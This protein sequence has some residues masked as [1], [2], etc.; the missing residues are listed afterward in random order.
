[1]I[2]RRFRKEAFAPRPPL[3]KLFGM[4]TVS[5]GCGVVE[6]LRVQFPSLGR[7]Q[8]TGALGQVYG[9]VYRHDCPAMVGRLGKRYEISADSRWA[10]GREWIWPDVLSPGMF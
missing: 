3:Q 5:S 2:V 7:S 9:R 6:Q 8:L 4:K 1:M 10:T